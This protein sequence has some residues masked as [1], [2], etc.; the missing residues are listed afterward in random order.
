M[1]ELFEFLYPT[2][3]IT[4]NLA[5]LPQIRKLLKE[6]GRAE[7]IS[8][9]AWI[10]WFLNSGISFGYAVMCVSDMKFAVTC[11]LGAT[12]SGV[13]CVLIIYHRFLKERLAERKF[14]SEQA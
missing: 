13:V 2:V 4:G 9:E 10:V 8:L 12:L 5:F 6:T 3:M 14:G 11:G 1:G 7:G